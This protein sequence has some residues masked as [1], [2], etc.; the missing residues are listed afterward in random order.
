L[1]GDDCCDPSD[2]VPGTGP[3]YGVPYL[4]LSLPSGNFVG[5]EVDGGLL[6]GRFL[7]APA[8][9]AAMAPG[10]P[11]GLVVLGLPGSRELRI[12]WTGE[13]AAPEELELFD[14]GGRLVRTLEARQADPG[15]S[16]DG[17]DDAGRPLAAGLY[18][19][20]T[21]PRRPGAH[22]KIVHLP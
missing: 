11:A 4:D 20:R 21:A 18:L 8:E 7:L 6:V 19:V 9:V 10:P 22:A 16:W 3:C 12:E 5:T 14:A 17:R 13:G 15:F 2:T 1:P